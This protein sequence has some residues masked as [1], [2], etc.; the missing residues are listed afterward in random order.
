MKRPSKALKTL[1]WVRELKES[2]AQQEYI[3]AEQALLKLKEMLK[4]IAQKPKEIFNEIEGKTFSGSE[5]KVFY[6]HV[7]QLLAEKEKI[8]GILE[9]KNQ[10]VENLRRKAVAAYQKRRVAEVLWTRAKEKYLKKLMEEEMKTIEDIVI[11]RGRRHEN[12]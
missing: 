6:Q 4:D 1:L 9:R 3:R 12:F 11:V 7:E 5:I 2:Q 8:E 10:E